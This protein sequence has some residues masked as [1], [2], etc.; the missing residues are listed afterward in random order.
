MNRKVKI[1]FRS[2]QTEVFNFEIE[3]NAIEFAKGILDFCAK[4][5]NTSG[6]FVS[7]G[8]EVLDGTA[9]SADSG[10]TIIRVD[11]IVAILCNSI[12]AK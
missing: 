6:A 10:F 3:E 2:G 8:S 11:D 5:A 1:L 7:I 4:N 12:R 9:D